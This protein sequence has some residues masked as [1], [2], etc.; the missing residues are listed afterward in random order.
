MVNVI[1]HERY[2]ELEPFIKENK[3]CLYCWKVLKRPIKTTYRE[4]DK[5]SSGFG[6]DFTCCQQCINAYTGGF[7]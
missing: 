4:T 1:S 6:K 3:V 7:H 5:Y 2:V